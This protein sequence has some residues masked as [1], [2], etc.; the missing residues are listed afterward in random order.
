MTAVRESVPAGTFSIS[1]NLHGNSVELRQV[2]EDRLVGR[3][4]YGNYM[5]VGTVRLLE[6]FARHL[7]EAGQAEPGALDPRLAALTPRELEVLR[8]VAEGMSNAEVA[9]QLFCSEA[10]VKTHVGRIL[11]KLGVR[12]RV[13]AVVLAYETGLVG[14]G[15]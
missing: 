4:A 14:G 2:T 9:E 12:D 13:Q 5:P 1:V 15:R 11:A 8:T 6:L 7:P 10:T 3:Y